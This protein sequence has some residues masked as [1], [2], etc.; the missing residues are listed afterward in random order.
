MAQV[1]TEPKNRLTFSPPSGC[2]LLL[3]DVVVL[4]HMWDLIVIGGT[5]SGGWRIRSERRRGGECR[6]PGKNVDLAGGE[7]SNSSAIWT[8]QT[9]VSARSCALG[10]LC[11]YCGTIGDFGSKLKRQPELPFGPASFR[12]CTDRR[13]LRIFVVLQRSS[14][15]LPC[16]VN[17]GL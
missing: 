2:F 13:R 11:H 5:L 1:V 6:E 15:G 9:M 17:Q 10:E 12:L 8:W 14:P 7:W 4:R 16:C 3:Y